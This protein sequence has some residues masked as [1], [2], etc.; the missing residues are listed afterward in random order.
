MS[1]KIRIKKGRAGFIVDGNCSVGIRVYIQKDKNFKSKVDS[2]TNSLSSE[3]KKHLRKIIYDIFQG[4][5]NQLV[6]DQNNNC[7][8]ERILVYN[9]N[10]DEFFSILYGMR[11]KS[12]ITKISDLRWS[13]A[14]A[15]ADKGYML[16]FVNNSDPHLAF[17]SYDIAHCEDEP[18]IDLDAKYSKEICGLKESSGTTIKKSHVVIT[19]LNIEED[20]NIKKSSPK[21]SVADPKTSVTNPTPSVTNPTPSA[22]DPK[23]S[24]AS[25]INNKGDK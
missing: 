16:I 18:I 13:I 23:N 21:T 6:K 8:P 2:Q 4:I 9:N 20:D 7:E 19:S 17:S 1:I 11:Y 14:N 22:T 24:L 3:G 15:C 5:Q 12:T 25:D 10:E